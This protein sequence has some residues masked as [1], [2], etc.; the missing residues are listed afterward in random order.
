MADGYDCSELVTGCDHAA[1]SQL[2]GLDLGPLLEESTGVTMRTVWVLEGRAGAAGAGEHPHR[3]HQSFSS[4][5]SFSGLRC[6]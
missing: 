4:K 1:E 5:P 6:P 3:A 2:R